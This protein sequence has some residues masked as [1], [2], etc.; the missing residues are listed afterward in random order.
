MRSKHEVNVRAN[1]RGGTRN[2][3]YE[4]GNEFH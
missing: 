4:L 1:I 3:I 2:L